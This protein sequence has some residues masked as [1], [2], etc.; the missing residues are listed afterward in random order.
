MLFWASYMHV[1]YIF[2]FALVQR[3]SACFTR[4]GALEIQSLL[5]SLLLF[6]YTWWHKYTHTHTYTNAHT[7]TH[8]HTCKHTHKR[9]HTCTQMHTHTHIHT[10]KHTHKHTHAYA[11]LH[12]Y[13]FT[14]GSMASGKLSMSYTLMIP[15]SPPSIKP[16]P[17]GLKT[18]LVSDKVKP[19]R[20]DIAGSSYKDT[21]KDWFFPTIVVKSYQTEE[22]IHV[23]VS[24]HTT[25]QCDWMHLLEH[26]CLYQGHLFC[27]TRK[28]ASKC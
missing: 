13:L 10:C 5:S 2:L 4:K 9:T 21:A 18:Q 22:L 16:R 7:H 17:D 15:S 20:K 14:L 6:T 23:P 19:T 24:D 12:L 27:Q 3:N 26:L 1:S 11:M 28:Q 25:I 8:P